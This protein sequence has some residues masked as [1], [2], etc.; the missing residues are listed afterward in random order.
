[1]SIHGVKVYPYKSLVSEPFLILDAE[2]VEKLEEALAEAAGT[3]PDN[4]V[5][6]E[7]RGMGGV[8]YIGF[9]DHRAYFSHEL[10][11]HKPPVNRQIEGDEE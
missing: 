5:V 3:H 10:G 4:H 6:Y 7:I 11:F 9:S 2:L 8:T 1:M